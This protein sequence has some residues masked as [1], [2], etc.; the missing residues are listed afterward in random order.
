MSRVK[1]P[2]DLPASPTPPASGDSCHGSV[3]LRASACHAAQPAAPIQ[4]V[5]G[6]PPMRSVVHCPDGLSGRS[7][8]DRTRAGQ[9]PQVSALAFNHLLKR[10]AHR[11]SCAGQ[12]ATLAGGD[13]RAGHALPSRPP[14]RRPRRR[15][16]SVGYGLALSGAAALGRAG[17]RLRPGHGCRPCWRWRRLPAGAEHHR[18][19]W[20]VLRQRTLNINA[21]DERGGDRRGVDRPVARSRDVVFVCAGRVCI[22]ARSLA[23]AATPSAA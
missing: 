4:P 16:P 1:N 21:L 13:C 14:M 12:R 8:Y 23:R 10:E 20:L 17:A 22:E 5:G 2:A 3:Q 15:R 11:R 6:R 7:Q 9:L 19:G 18:K